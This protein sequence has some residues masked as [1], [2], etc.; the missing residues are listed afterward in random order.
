MYAY[1][2][3]VGYYMY[4]APQ[5]MNPQQ[6]AVQAIY[7]VM[8]L[9]IFAEAM[10]LIVVASGLSKVPARLKAGDPAVQ[11]LRNAFGDSVVDRALADVPGAEAV[12]LAKRVEHYVYQDL[13]ATYGDWA[14]NIAINSAPIGDLRTAKEIARALSERNI[15]QSSSVPEKAK[16]VARGKMRGRSLAEPVR[17]TKTGTVYPSKYK[18]GLAVATEYGFVADQYAYFKIIQKDKTRFVSA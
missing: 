6:F 8:S 2:G 4:Y 17:D 12:E 1:D 15:T 10:G 5:Q 11:E 9:S 16:A 14:A 7:T 18:A 13:R 3:N